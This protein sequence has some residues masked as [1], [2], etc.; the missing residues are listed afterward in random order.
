[1]T[2][3]A[4]K[5]INAFDQPA[6][7]L[8]FNFSRFEKPREPSSRT[9]VVLVVLV[10]A[11]TLGNQLPELGRSSQRAFHARPSRGPTSVIKPPLRGKPRG[12]PAHPFIVAL[13]TAMGGKR[14]ER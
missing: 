2:D 3:A 7:Q 5:R 8:I 1:M 12:T 9:S 6:A 10:V 14:L 4:G 11:G 13:A